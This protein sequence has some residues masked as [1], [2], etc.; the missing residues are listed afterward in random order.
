MK[1]AIGDVPRKVICETE[2]EAKTIEALGNQHGGI[3][4]PEAPVVVPRLVLDVAFEAPV[5]GADRICRLSN[6]W[7]RQSSSFKRH[8]RGLNSIREFEKRVNKASRIRPCSQHS[9]LPGKLSGD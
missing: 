7:V 1:V 2:T 5:D 8:A 3:W 9:L 6:N 4:R